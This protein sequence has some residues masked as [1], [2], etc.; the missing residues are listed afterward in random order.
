[1]LAVQFDRY[2]GTDV[3]EVRDIPFPELKPGGAIVRVR[4]AGL[5]TGE[6]AIREGRFAGGPYERFPSGL[7]TDLAGEVVAVGSEV[8][9][10]R[11]SADVL[12]WTEERTAEAEF[13]AVPATQLVPKPATLSWEAA[14]VLFGSSMAGAASVRAV[15]CGPGDNL[16]V[17]AA[18]GGAGGMACQLAVRTRARV[19]GLA[20]AR[21]H[22]WL[23]AHGVVPVG[24]GDGV[25]DRI[26]E[27]LGGGAPSALIDAFGDG[28]VELGLRMGIRPE[29]INTLIDFEAAAAHP[30]VKTD[31]TF[32]IASAQLLG[33]M[34]DLAARGELDVPIAARFEL[35]DVRKAYEQLATRHT[36][37]KIALLVG[38]PT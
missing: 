34:A 38:E 24:Y 15:G 35:R 33:K 12:G 18:A 13:V 19:V 22:D 25:D 6:I 28:Y 16:V 3:L 4:V 31:G 9:S 32:S 8:T 1:M 7:G 30:G 29:R 26:R 11:V 21:H 23:R 5:N 36:R 17:S 20:S 37:G 27:A 14:G 10:L 2:G